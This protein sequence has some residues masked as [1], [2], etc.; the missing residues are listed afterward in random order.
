MYH[1]SQRSNRKGIETLQEA[2]PSLP[3][4]KYLHN[5]LSIISSSRHTWPVIDHVIF[6]FDLM[7]VHVIDIRPY[8]DVGMLHLKSACSMFGEGKVLVGGE[9]GMFIQYQMKEKTQRERCGVPRIRSLFDFRTIIL[10]YEMNSD[11]H[12]NYTFLHAP[13]PSAANAIYVN[14]VLIRRDS[15]EFPASEKFF[16]GRI[17]KAKYLLVYSCFEASDSPSFAQL[18]INQYKTMEEM[19]KKSGLTNCR[20][21]MVHLHVAH[22]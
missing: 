1:N 8:K 5:V 14:N 20:K 16:A 9:L 2:F 18:L 6:L 15:S 3:V 21:L 13:D 7:Q 11:I 19:S 17:P 10:L 4:S 12:R 22:C